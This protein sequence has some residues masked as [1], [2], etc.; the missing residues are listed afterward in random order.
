MIYGDV[1][2][3]E[4]FFELLNFICMIFGYMNFMLIWTFG[5]ELTNLVKIKLSTCCWVSE[6]TGGMVTIENVIVKSVDVLFSALSLL[7]VKTNNG[8]FHFH[9]IFWNKKLFS[10]EGD[11]GIWGCQNFNKKMSML[12]FYH[13][14]LH[15]GPI[16][17]HI[18]NPWVNLDWMI[19]LVFHLRYM[20][21]AFIMFIN[22]QNPDLLAL[23]FSFNFLPF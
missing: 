19:I 12:F 2:N 16:W 6:L 17:L 9:K 4:R 5:A 10:E 22:F 18:W 7:V 14:Y 23:K 3:R 13:L 11:M 21:C 15:C 1:W 20:K 8:Y